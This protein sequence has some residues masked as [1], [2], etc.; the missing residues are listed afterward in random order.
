MHQ[1]SGAI[2]A[3]IGSPFFLVKCRIQ[4]YSPVAHAQVGV[5]HAYSGLV[6]AFRSI[7][8]AEGTRGLL[9]GVEGGI[10]RVMAGSASQLASYDA[11]KAFVVGTLGIPD[12]VYGHIA[13]SL[14]A[15]AWHEGGK[16]RG[17]RPIG[18]ADEQQ[19]G[20]ETDAAKLRQLIGAAVKKRD[21]KIVQL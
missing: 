17:R 20:T 6:D 3:L 7:V 14:V 9:R 15:G 1:H 10:P 11:S 8:R 5:Q 13:A 16:G 19:Q 21:H 18:Y 4:A 12:D 2:G